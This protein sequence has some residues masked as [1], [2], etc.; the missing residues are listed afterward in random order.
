[1]SERYCGTLDII[2][3][4]SLL[5]LIIMIGFGLYFEKTPN[6]VSKLII[7]W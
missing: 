2:I 1:M 7:T 4:I 5:I 3:F 6:E